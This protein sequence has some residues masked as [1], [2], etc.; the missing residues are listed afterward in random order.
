M[1][2]FSVVDLGMGRWHW[3]IAQEWDGESRTI[4]ESGDHESEFVCVA[5]LN[6]VIEACRQSHVLR[7]RSNVP[8][9]STSEAFSSPPGAFVPG[10]RSLALRVVAP[11]L[12]SGFPRFGRRAN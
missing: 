5:E 6:E 12:S 10:M 1:T 7:C 11:A 4:A 8:P 2:Q 3:R 9:S